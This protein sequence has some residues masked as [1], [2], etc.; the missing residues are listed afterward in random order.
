MTFAQRVLRQEIA[1]WL[2]GLRTIGAIRDYTIESYNEETGEAVVRI[3]QP[4][5]LAR[6]EIKGRYRDVVERMVREIEI[7][8]EASRK[9]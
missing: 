9:L 8:G 4:P 3:K 7:A 1:D 5:V 6:I 2:A